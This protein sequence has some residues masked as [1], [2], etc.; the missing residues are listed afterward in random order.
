MKSLFKN[1]FPDSTAV[2]TFTKDFYKKIR[3][4]KIEKDILASFD[5]ENMHPSIDK[6]E[7]LKIVNRKIEKKFVMKKSP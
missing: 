3:Q 7:L 2:L 4:L 1:L 5:I 6:D